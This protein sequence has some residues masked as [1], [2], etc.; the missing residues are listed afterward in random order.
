MIEEAT[1]IMKEGI[2]Q[3]VQMNIMINNR[4][5]GNGPRIAQLLAERFLSIQ[6][7]GTD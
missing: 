2:R 4:A 5:G 1:K 3:N 7:E 6:A